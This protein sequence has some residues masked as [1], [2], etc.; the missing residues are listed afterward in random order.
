M[1]SR[2][3]PPTRLVSPPSSPSLFAADSSPPSSPGLDTSNL[4]LDDSP[5]IHPFAASSKALP[6]YEK[7]VRSFA[8]DV[9]AAGPATKKPRRGSFTKDVDDS[10]LE[11]S[12]PS[13]EFGNEEVVDAEAAEWDRVITEVI[14]HGHG[15]V[16]LEDRELTYIPGN[17]MRD[18]QGF[19]ALSEKAE[20]INA[21]KIIAPAL[22]LNGRR[23]M[24]RV[25]TA[26]ASTS[27]DMFSP[28][29][30][31]TSSLGNLGLPREEIQLFLSRNQIQ[32][33]PRQLFQVEKLT[34]LIIRANSLTS[35]PP[36]IS[37]LANLREL[38]IAN[39]KIRYLPSEI[40][41]LS[42]AQLHVH[43]NPFLPIPASL[44]PPISKRPFSRSRSLWG[45]RALMESRETERVYTKIVSGV[46]RKLPRVIPLQEICL[47]HVFSPCRQLPSNSP[48]IS[49][50]Q[51]R[52]HLPLLE[53][54]IWSTPSSKVRLRTPLPDHLE[55]LFEAISPG[56][57]YGEECIH[58]DP[59]PAMVPTPEE[60][61][62]RITGVGTCPSPHHLSPGS[63]S[64]PSL[65]IHHAEE[66]FTWEDTVAGILV[67]GSV[68]IR[69]R[70][71]QWGC[72]DFLDSRPEISSNATS[73]SVIDEAATE[74]ATTASGDIVDDVETLSTTEDED[75]D[76]A[77]VAV[78]INR[79][80]DMSD[81][82]D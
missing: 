2:R 20:L 71:C 16:R 12:F 32:T 56:C 45:T 38:N 50:L 34:V 61:D 25:S 27:S 62:A 63:R 54:D 33:L 74:I 35:I 26:P 67:G 57:T 46:S 68:P 37:K 42:L 1:F 51:A 49:V 75:R 59:D 19:R 36:E 44:A 11:S 40:L 29:P 13:I 78:D 55:S 43:P 22:P 73:S 23:Q 79:G 15:T 41:L 80:L 82:E 48:P 3:S 8:S 10:F 14:D 21:R 24:A 53:P 77:V 30:E 6:G 64:T 72:L 52:Y 4:Q 5:L 69:W 17:A 39:N 28:F 81:F 66:R 18:L 47:R 31:R 70:G 76:I 65:F 58:Q 7:R 9:L 60:D